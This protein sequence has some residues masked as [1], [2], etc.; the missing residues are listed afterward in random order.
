MCMNDKRLP[1]KLLSNKWE[2]VKCKG[3]PRKSWF[4]RVGVIKKELNLQDKV[5]DVKLVLKK[6][7]I[8]ENVLS[9]KRSF[10]IN[11]HY[12]FIGR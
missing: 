2:N 4:A 11:P 8:T 7:L 12:I 9:L 3:R 5:L 10:S 6:A 1:G